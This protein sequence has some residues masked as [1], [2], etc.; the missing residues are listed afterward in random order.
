MYAV[1]NKQTNMFQTEFPCM[2][3]NYFNTK[4]HTSSSNGLLLTAIRLKAKY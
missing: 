3:K 2:F 4:L 1:A